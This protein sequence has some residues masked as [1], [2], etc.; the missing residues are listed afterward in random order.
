MDNA[1]QTRSGVGTW[2]LLIALAGAVVLTG[3]GTVLYLRDGQ[4]APLVAGIASIVAVLAAIGLGSQLSSTLRQTTASSDVLATALTERLEQFSVM[5]N[6]ISEQQLISERAKAIAFRDKDH[7]AMLRAMREE[8][9]RGQ[10]DAALLLVNE[11]EAAM[12]YKQEAEQLRNEIA[13]MREGT[14]RHAIADAVAQIDRQCS[15]EKWDEAIAA[16]D[17]LADRYPGHDMTVDL[18]RQIRAR[19]ESIKQQLLQRW[20]DAVERKDIDASVEVL[21]SLDIYVTASEVAQLKD[22]ALE[23]FKAR[24]E[25]LREQFKAGVQEHR[26]NDAIT[27]GQSIV[28]EFPTSKLAQEVRDIMPSLHEKVAEAPTATAGT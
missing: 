9:S 27:A 11:M 24:I 14:T 7:E 5:L 6:M 23:I 18:P 4:H 21:R 26:W 28:E 17:Q 20:K 22:G 25:S 16:A 13:Q 3:F 10:Y 19:R 12:G 8:L 2:V 1:K 15:A